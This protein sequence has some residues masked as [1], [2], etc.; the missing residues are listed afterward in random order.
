MKKFSIVCNYCG[1]SFKH[2]RKTKLYCSIECRHQ[3]HESQFKSGRKIRMPKYE[4][5]DSYK[6]DWDWIEK[7]LDNRRII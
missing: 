2:E 4:Y 7:N 3:Q 5:D 1:N 6:Y